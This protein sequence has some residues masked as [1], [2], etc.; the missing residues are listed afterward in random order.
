MQRFSAAW[1]KGNAIEI[2]EEFTKDAVR[3]I[4][5]PSSPI[6]GQEAIQDAFESTFS[7][8]SEFKNSHI[9]VTIVE[10]RSVSADVYL[11]A[12]KFKI[13][14]EENEILEQGKWGNVFKYDNGQIKKGSQNKC[15]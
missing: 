8:G 15:L 5:N 9:E 14:N 4:S 2:S 12:G 3:I 10:T 13:L 1:N 7:D 11:G 6:K